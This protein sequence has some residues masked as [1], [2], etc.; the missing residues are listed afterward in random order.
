MTKG[1]N[2]N[3]LEFIR[4]FFS[5]SLLIRSILKYQNLLWN[6]S[7]INFLSFDLNNVFN[8]IFSKNKFISFNLIILLLFY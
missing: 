7:K 4:K 2:Y 8:L 5:Q 3:L 1:R 6:I